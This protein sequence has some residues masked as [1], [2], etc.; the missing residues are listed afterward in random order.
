MAKNFRTE[1]ESE[2]KELEN[3]GLL[4]NTADTLT[5][6]VILSREVV[7]AVA[8]GLIALR[9]VAYKKLED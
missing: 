6:S 1:V 7:S 4:A 2:Y 8:K 3:K 9:L 5:G